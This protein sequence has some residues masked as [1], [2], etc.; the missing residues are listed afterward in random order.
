M[1][2]SVRVQF[3]ASIGALSLRR[4]PRSRYLA[5]RLRRHHASRPPLA[6]MRPGKP[7]PT[8]GPGT[9]NSGTGVKVPLIENCGIVR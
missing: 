8:I 5:F 3:S 2:D 6:K 9:L 4:A 1:A 7:L